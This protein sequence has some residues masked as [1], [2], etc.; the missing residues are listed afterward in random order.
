MSIR[1]NL[2]TSEPRDVIYAMLGISSDCMNGEIIPDYG[3]PVINIYREVLQLCG[4]QSA[5]PTFQHKLAWKLGLE[6][7]EICNIVK[8]AVCPW[9]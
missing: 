2:Q 4:A 3:K 9:R 7:G 1:A 8:S 5:S 6:H